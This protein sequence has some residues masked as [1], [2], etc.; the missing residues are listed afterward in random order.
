[1]IVVDQLDLEHTKITLESFEEYDTIL[2]MK[3][4]AINL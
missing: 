3:Q 2:P 1:M 4:K